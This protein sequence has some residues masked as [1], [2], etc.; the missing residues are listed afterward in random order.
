MRKTVKFIP[1]IA[2]LLIGFSSCMSH[3]M[4]TG[5]FEA[6]STTINAGESITFDGSCSEDTHHWEWDFGDGSTGEGETVAHAYNNP[7]TY[8]VTLEAHNEDMTEMDEE[9]ITITV[10]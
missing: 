10:N 6:S 7:G 8:D 3:N 5:C 1:V 4:P 2:I 9:M